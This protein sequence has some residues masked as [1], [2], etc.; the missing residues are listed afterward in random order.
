MKHLQSFVCLSAC[1]SALT[2]QENPSFIMKL[3][4]P[5]TYSV[6]SLVLETICGSDDLQHVESYDNSFANWG[7]D[8]AF[9]AQSSPSV[10]ALFRTSNPYFCSGT[11]IANDL[12]LTAS[13]C[14]DSYVLGDL[15]VFNYQNDPNGQLR[16]VQ[17]FPVVEVIEDAEGGLDYAILRL[18][19]NA[20]G[21][22]PGE[23][24]GYKTLSATI[25]AEVMIIQH[26]SREPKQLDA[27]ENLATSGIYF[28]YGDLDTRG[29]SSG[30]GVV[31]NHN[32]IVAV[33]T[34][35]GCHQNGGYNTG[36][37][38]GAIADKSA[39]TRFALR[40]WGGNVFRSGSP[41]RGDHIYSWYSWVY[42]GS[43][44]GEYYHYDLGWQYIDPN[45][46]SSS[47]YI[48]DYNISG[49][50]WTSE[51]HYPSIY[52]HSTNQWFINTAESVPPGI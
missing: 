20:D 34:N 29:G 52:N 18:G 42:V 48:Y 10:G 2:A 44:A 6:H 11:L 7:F 37:R 22:L 50:L 17:T 1:L 12:F 33:H 32:R 41:Y 31:D 45:Q 5:D 3:Y 15:V 35:G 39:M 13:H 30:S 46:D 16:T 19:A 21:N 40:G 28:T 47:V 36:V 51:S 8:Q 24:Y 49:W 26:P 43:N 23:T 27:G 38:V 9:V 4:D 25:P 14:V